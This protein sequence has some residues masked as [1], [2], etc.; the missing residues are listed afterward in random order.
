M[1]SPGYREG[2]NPAAWRGHLDHLLSAPKKTATVEHHPA[3][4]WRLLGSF[5]EDLRSMTGMAALALETII[6]TN[7]RTSEAIEATWSES[8][9]PSPVDYP[10]RADESLQGAH[11]P[12]ERAGSGRPAQGAAGGSSEVFVFPTARAKRVNAPAEKPMSNMG[13]LQLL[14]RMGRQNLTVH[15][16]RSTFR[17]GPARLLP[18]H[19]RSSSTP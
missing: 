13:C 8:T 2:D 3:L 14:K 12:L 16:F 11:N 7:C 5:M 18:I 10:R 4:P 19:E 1:Q 6:L 9:S 17:T 15:G